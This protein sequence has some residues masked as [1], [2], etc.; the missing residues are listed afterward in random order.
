MA[1]DWD[2]DALSLSATGLPASVALDPATG[3][4]AG[5]FPAAGVYVI[6]ATASDGTLSNSRTFTWTVAR[7]NHAP[8]L[9][10]PGAQTSSAIFSYQ[11]AVERDV[12]LAYWRLHD[13]T[14]GTAADAMDHHPATVMGGV[15]TGQ[16]GPLADGSQ[17]M[18]S[19]ARTPTS[20]CRMRRPYSCP[21]AIFSSSDLWAAGVRQTLISEG[22]PKRVPAAARTTGR[23]NLYQGNGVQ[24]QGVLSVVGAVVPNTWQHIVVTRSAATKTI[25]FYV[26]GVAKGGGVDP[27]A[28][29][30]DQRNL[31]RPGAERHPARER[32]DQRCGGV[33]EP[34][35]RRAGGCAPCDANGIRHRY[36]DRTAIVGERRRRRAGDLQ[37]G[38]T[39]ARLDA[40]RGHGPDHR[41]GVVNSPGIVCRDGSPYPTAAFRPVRA[42]PGR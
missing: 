22:L 34:A 36:A 4:I 29:T 33:F 23:L 6:T 14:G 21:D 28:P 31:D 41:Y 10:N 17:A 11:G 13:D 26:N 20:A 25:A 16:E 30:T 35:R 24:Y 32:A 15:T 9:T 39:A 38:G 2:G 7:F 8:L 42:S 40:R 5:A 19:T 1:T 37:R 18:G 12:P 3:L 27:V